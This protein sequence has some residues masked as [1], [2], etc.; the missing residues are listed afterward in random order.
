MGA[1]SLGSVLSLFHT[2]LPEA[3]QPF[4]NQD[5]EEKGRLC[6]PGE[7]ILSTLHLPVGCRAV[8]SQG[9]PFK[10]WSFVYEE[11]GD[12]ASLLPW[13]LNESH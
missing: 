2:L 6:L 4:K 13:T 7:T 1:V 3:Q 5:Q 9:N 8:W 12:K 10:A 11:D